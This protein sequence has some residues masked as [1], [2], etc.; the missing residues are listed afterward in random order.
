MGLYRQADPPGCFPSLHKNGVF[1][2][3]RST[4]P[5]EYFRQ[6]LAVP[7]PVIEPKGTRT[8]PPQKSGL[9]PPPS[10][11]FAQGIGLQQTTVSSPFRCCLE[12]LVTAI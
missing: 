6:P 12:Q 8:R 9:P 3:V 10:C 11:I 5:A 4:P 2:K 7:H 1:I